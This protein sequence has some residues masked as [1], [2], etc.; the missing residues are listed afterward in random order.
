MCYFLYKYCDFQ[1][2][3][4]NICITWIKYKIPWR[5]IFNQISL[6]PCQHFIINLILYI[7]ASIDV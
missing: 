6:S 4:N 5:L 3:F 1:G 2:F 7:S